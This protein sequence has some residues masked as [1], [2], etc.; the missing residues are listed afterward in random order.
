MVGSGIL[1]RSYGKYSYVL[2]IVVILYEITV[3]CCCISIYFYFTLHR[4][5][6]KLPD[7][8]QYFKSNMDEAKKLVKEATCL[9]ME[10]PL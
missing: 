1:V 3:I 9:Y 10:S 7:E 8:S 2:G 6:V 5:F 4:K